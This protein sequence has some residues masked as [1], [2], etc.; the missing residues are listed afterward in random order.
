MEDSGASRN[1]HDYCDY[2]LNGLH[3]IREKISASQSAI[4]CFYHQYLSPNSAFSCKCCL[5]DEGAPE[6]TL[7]AKTCHWLFLW[8]PGDSP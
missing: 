1:A 4:H 5:Q 2:I 8:I 3:E 7:R 6:G